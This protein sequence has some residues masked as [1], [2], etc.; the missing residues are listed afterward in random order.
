M[1]HGLEQ[2]VRDHGNYSIVENGT[3]RHV[4][5]PAEISHEEFDPGEEVRVEVV[6]EDDYPVMRVV[7]EEAFD[8]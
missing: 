8:V 1:R 6:Q 2:R 7:P 5:V 4:T 3:G